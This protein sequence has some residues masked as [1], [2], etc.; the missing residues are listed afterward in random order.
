MKVLY[1]RKT[2]KRVEVSNDVKTMISSGKSNPI[3]RKRTYVVRS[4]SLDTM[5]SVQVPREATRFR[6]RRKNGFRMRWEAS[7]KRT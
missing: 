4:D 3:K 5:S 1:I 2:M 6:R 7:S